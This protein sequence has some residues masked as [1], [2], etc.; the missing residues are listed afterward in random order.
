MMQQQ[1]LKLEEARLVREKHEDM[2]KTAKQKNEED[3]Q[4]KREVL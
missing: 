4:R 2:L 1:A 3:L